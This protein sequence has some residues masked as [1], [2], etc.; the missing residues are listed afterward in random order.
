MA[1][2]FPSVS[3]SKKERLMLDVSMEEVKAALFSIG[4]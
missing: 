2:T 3:N 1:C 4:A